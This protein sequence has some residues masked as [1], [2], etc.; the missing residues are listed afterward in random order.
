LHSLAQGRD[1]I[2]R[3]ELSGAEIRL[4]QVIGNNIDDIRT[5]GNL[6]GKLSVL[7]RGHAE[8]I[9]HI[10][11]TSWLYFG[12]NWHDEGGKNQPG[13]YGLPNIHHL[14]VL[15]EFPDMANR[16]MPWHHDYFQTP[17]LV[18]ECLISGTRPS[19]P[20]MTSLY[21]WLKPICRLSRHSPQRKTAFF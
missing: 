1:T 11:H 9:L 7:V 4:A 14:D 15:N 8:A 12:L 17:D 20:G 5:T 3:A 21:R 10:S 2:I 16:T 19:C 18:W 13:Y 6:Y